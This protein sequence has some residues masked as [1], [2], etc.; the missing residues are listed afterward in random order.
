MRS[1]FKKKGKLELEEVIVAV[2][3]ILLVIIGIIF[4]TQFKE[5][6]LLGIEK[7]KEIFGR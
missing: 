6:M 4:L 7:L 1:I 2:L 3:I 5:K